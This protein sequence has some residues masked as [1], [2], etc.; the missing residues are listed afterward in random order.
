MDC[1]VPRNDKPKSLRVLPRHCEAEGRSNPLVTARNEAVQDSAVQLRHLWIAAA[2]GLAVTSP[3]Q[4]GPQKVHK[5]L[6]I[7]GLSTS[8]VAS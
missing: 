6:K 7:L 4:G 2:Y 5:A 8:D 1:L 3:R